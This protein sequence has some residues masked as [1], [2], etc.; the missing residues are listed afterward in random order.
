L[1][2]AEKEVGEHDP[3]P[4]RRPDQQQRDGEADQPA[5]DEHRL[6][7]VPVACHLSGRQLLE[8]AGFVAIEETDYTSEFATVAGA[9]I[10]QS[11]RHR[12]A[13][14]EVLGGEAIDQRQHE[15]RTQ[16]RAVNDGLLR[17]S[18]LVAARPDGG[19]P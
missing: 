13:L 18:L 4:R 7:P 14:A 9:W 2:D 15:R 12:D 10:E 11:D 16:L 8:R 1:V 5:G 6:A 19:R 17:R 3:S